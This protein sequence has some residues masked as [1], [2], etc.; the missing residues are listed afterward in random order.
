M[1]LELCLSSGIGEAGHENRKMGPRDARGGTWDLGD[2]GRSHQFQKGVKRKVGPMAA[3]AWDKY[4]EADDAVA[5]GL[6]LRRC[7]P[8]AMGV[9]IGE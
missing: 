6:A 4:A 1:G 8:A 9:H 2:L 5:R 7:A 3:L